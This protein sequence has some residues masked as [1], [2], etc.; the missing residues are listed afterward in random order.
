MRYRL[1]ENPEVRYRVPEQ[2]E[3]RCRVPGKRDCEAHTEILYRGSGFPVTGSAVLVSLVT[4]TA[5]LVSLVT[6]TAVLVSRWV[7]IYR[8]LMVSSTLPP[9]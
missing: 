6:G 8:L 2:Q 9:Q 3:V 7:F 4:G 1:P 5:V